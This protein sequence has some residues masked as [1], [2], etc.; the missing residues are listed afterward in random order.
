MDLLLRVE[1]WVDEETSGKAKYK[2]NDVVE[3]GWEDVTSIEEV[4]A[5]WWKCPGIDFKRARD[6]VSSLVTD[7]GGFASLTSPQKDIACK[8]KIGAFADR[9][10]HC[11]HPT[12][13]TYMRAYNKNTRICREQR[14]VESEII[15]RNELPSNHK[16]YFDE[17]KEVYYNYFFFAVEGIPNNDLEGILDYIWGTAGTTWAGAGLLN[18]AWTPETMNLNDLCSHLNDILSGGKYFFT[19]PD[20]KNWEII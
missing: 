11:G 5:N 20:G 19:M 17:S 3:A 7:T 4:Y 12:N 14:Q 6:L 13:L 18:K 8:Y 15:A 10:A 2:F 1:G 16:D 9:V